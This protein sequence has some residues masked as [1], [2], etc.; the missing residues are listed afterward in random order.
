MSSVLFSCVSGADPVN[1]KKD[2]PMLHIIRKYRPHAV[3]IFETQENANCQKKDGRYSKA[4][5]KFNKDY[6]CDIEYKFIETGITDPSDYDV[7]YNLFLEKMDMIVHDNPNDVVLLNLS[8]GTPQMQTSMC[9]LAVN[10]KYKNTRGIQVSSPEHGPNKTGMSFDKD[11]DVDVELEFNE[12]NNKERMDDDRYKEPPIES[13]KNTIA[14]GQIHSFISS[15]NYRAAKFIAKEY[16]LGSDVKA[17]IGHLENRQNFNKNAENIL[18]AHID[19]VFYPIEAGECRKLTEAYLVLLNLQKINDFTDFV[20]RLNPVIVRL[21]KDLLK[22]KAGFD[23]DSVYDY[24]QKKV[25]A[26]LLKRKDPGLF[27]YLN[28]KFQDDDN[29]DYNNSDWNM[30]M[31]TYIIEYIFKGKNE[32]KQYIE[33]LNKCVK[34]NQWRN[35]AAHSIYV[36]S[37]VEIEACDLSSQEILEKLKELLKFTFPRKCK[38]KIFTI[39]DDINKLIL[40]R[41]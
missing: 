7:S 10:T 30:K 40:D 2:G 26:E 1:K 21:Q 12:D 22:E 13:V 15:Y 9:L 31:L 11:Y 35:T 17:L 39:Y 5:E 25:T 41:I 8:S 28:K 34:L 18:N 19:F 6:N 23:C 38:D 24:K 3:Y 14:K 20:L 32:F 36:V 27:Q 4:I 37:E 16:D 29:H 33:F